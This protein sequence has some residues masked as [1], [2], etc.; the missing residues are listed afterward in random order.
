M[1]KILI[2]GG[3]GFV[4]K[5]LINFLVGKGYFIH[6]LTRKPSANSIENI[7]FFQWDIERQ[8]INKKAFEGVEILINL[9]GANIGEK[10]WTNDRKKEIIDSRIKSISLLY[11]YIS[12]NKFNIN[13]FILSS[14][15]GFYGAVTTEK[16]FAETSE[17]GND[18]LASVCQKWE[19]AALK[20]NDLGVRTVILRKGVILGKD[21]GMVKKLSPLA[22]LGINVSLGS[23]EQYLPWID[24]R[25][26]VKLYNFIL[27]NAQLNGIYNA[28]ATEQMTMNDFSKALLKSFGKKSFLPNAP[29]FVIR[30]L[31]GEMAVMLLEGSK[32]S[33]EKLKNT[34]FYFEFDTIERSL[35]L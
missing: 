21:G 14:A 29:A 11:Q 16:T 35:C 33:N 2:A 30:L 19:N 34:G 7:C 27:S 13:T 32:V 23:G 20:F 5:Q 25:D 6:V 1:K 9:T 12:E 22:K 3:T 17:R 31:F 26:L 10:R 4:G 8:Y 28:V 24:I 15:V 18:F